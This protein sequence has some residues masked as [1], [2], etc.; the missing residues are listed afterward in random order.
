[1]LP[2]ARFWSHFFPHKSASR[3]CRTQHI[4][5]GWL[6]LFRLTIMKAPVPFWKSSGERK[7]SLPSISLL[8]F[9]KICQ[10]RGLVRVAEKMWQAWER[11]ILFFKKK[12][13]TKN[14]SGYSSCPICSPASKPRVH[15]VKDLHD[16]F[17]AIHRINNNFA[18]Y[19]CVCILILI[20]IHL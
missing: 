10:I 20:Y 14:S 19:F 9:T 7:L 18:W 3:V 11:R 13:R 5:L 2:V 8:F 12:K 16:Y 1:M 17:P 4:N 6:R 15:N